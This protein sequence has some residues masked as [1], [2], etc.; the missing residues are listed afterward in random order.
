MRTIIQTIGPLYGEV[1]NGSVFG[2]PNGSVA[3]QP[4]GPSNPNTLTITN[5]PGYIVGVPTTG[6]KY[7]ITFCDSGGETVA[8]PLT[9]AATSNVDFR[10][11][12]GVTIGNE[13]SG[14]TWKIN[15]SPV[16]MSKFAVVKSTAPVAGTT[17]TVK[18]QLWDADGVTLLED[19]FDVVGVSSE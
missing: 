5:K 14:Q 18:V 6:G 16:T 17:Y 19:S 2:Q 13:G 9:I 3:V 11:Y 7:T 8:T 10:I 4:S 15:E 12:V 1:V